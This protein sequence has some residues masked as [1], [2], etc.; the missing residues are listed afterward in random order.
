MLKKV[1]GSLGVWHPQKEWHGL[2][3]RSYSLTVKD[4]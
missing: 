3:G 1:Y 4:S 2:W